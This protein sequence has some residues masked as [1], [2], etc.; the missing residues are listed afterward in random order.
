MGSSSRLTTLVHGITGADPRAADAARRRFAELAVPPGA[1]GELVDIGARLAAIAGDCPPP[2]PNDP[3]LVVAAADHGVYAQQVSPWPQTV[4]AAM[5]RTLCEG[6]AT[7]NAFAGVTGVRVRVLDVGLATPVQDGPGLCRAN[8]APGTRD[9]SVEPAMTSREV[10]DAVLAGVASAEELLGEG[11]DLLVTGDMGIANTTAAAALVTAFAGRDAD[12]VTG[13]GTGVDDATMRRKVAAVA[14]AVARHREDGPWDMLAGVGGLEHAA[15]VG[16]ILAG[17]A[18]RVP[19]LL[20]GVSAGAAALAAAAI[21]PASA[22]H[23]FAGHRSTEPGADVALA[24]LG[25]RPLLDLGLRLGEGT[26]ALLAVPILRAAA[27]ALHEVATLDEVTGT[28][29]DP[30]GA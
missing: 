29:A 10:T 30:A 27:A 7:A 26:G 19:V 24:Q 4:T 5:V 15:L 13:P 22:D 6:R 12:E 25:L 21:A 11:V 17:A 23:L 3:G 8:V 20:D 2:V 1:L 28:G 9:L 16:V 18:A 14:A